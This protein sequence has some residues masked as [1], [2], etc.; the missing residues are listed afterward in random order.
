MFFENT[1]KSIC[2]KIYDL[3]KR[4]PDKIGI[5]YLFSQAFC[6]SINHFINKLSDLN[7]Q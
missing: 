1:I 6:F 7:S 2:Y 3:E 5:I 4:F